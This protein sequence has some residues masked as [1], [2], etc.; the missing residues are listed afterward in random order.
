MASTQ[1]AKWGNSLAARI[2]KAVAEDAQLREGEPVTVTVAHEGSL[3][4]KPACRKVHINRLVAR[5]TAKNKHGETDWGET[6]GQGDWVKRGW[7][8]DTGDLVWLTFDPQAGRKQAGP[9][10][11]V[12][13]SILKPALTGLP[14]AGVVLADQLKSL[15]WRTRRAEPAGRPPLSILRGVLDRLAPLLGY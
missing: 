1:L 8:P 6:Q 9:R 15:D 5:I 10:R 2:P 11:A 13:R 14:I 3:V 4:I 7:A 12:A